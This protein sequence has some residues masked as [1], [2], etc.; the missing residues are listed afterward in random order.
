MG[1]L[2]GDAVDASVAGDGEGA[3]RVDVEAAG[4]FG[5]LAVRG[6]CVAPIG[7]HAAMNA[8][9]DAAPA[10]RSVRAAT[11]RRACSFKRPR[12]VLI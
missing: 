11:R 9:S 7:A 10:P 5:A 4:A 3:V 8:T 2:A 12:E 6:A 1:A